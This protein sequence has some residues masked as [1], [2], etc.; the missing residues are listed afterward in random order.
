MRFKKVTVYKFE[1][2][3]LLNEFVELSCYNVSKSCSL[4]GLTVLIVAY[5]TSGRMF[6]EHLSVLANGNCN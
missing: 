3:A 1:Q 2:I 4:L 5:S 6:R